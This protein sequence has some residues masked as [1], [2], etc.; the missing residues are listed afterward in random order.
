MRLS[1]ADGTAAGSPTPPGPAIA[2]GA[3]LVVV[4]NNDSAEQLRRHPQLPPHRP[5][6]DAEAIL[7]QDEEAQ[8]TWTVTFQPDATYTFQD[9]YRP[10]LIHLVFRTSSSAAAATP[11]TSP[12]GGTPAVTTG[13]PAT[14]VN[15][16]VVG[17]SSALRSAEP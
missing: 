12:T 11:S 15:P 8:A 7:T 3:Y 9:D 6:V 1:L 14:I 10:G 13:S 4:N 17:S 2:P 16:D 5:G